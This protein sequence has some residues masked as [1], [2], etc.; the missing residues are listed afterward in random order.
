MADHDRIGAESLRDAAA[1][2]DPLAGFHPSVAR[3]FTER[4]GVPSP[5]QAEGWPL[6]RT[7]AHTLIAAPTGSGKT[8]AAFLWALDGLLRQGTDLKDETQ[9]LYVSPL[10]A[11]SNDVQKNLQAPLAELTLLESAFAPVRVP[12]RPGATP[13]RERAAVRRR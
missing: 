8:L 12:V 4:I 3:W 2:A 9:V 13:A 10:K 1:G 7:G 5:A 11:L 6:I